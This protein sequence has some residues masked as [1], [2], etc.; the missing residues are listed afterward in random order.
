[1]VERD[2]AVPG[3]E[4][5]PEERHRTQSVDDAVAMALAREDPYAVIDILADADRFIEI[6]GRLAEE[7]RSA[8]ARGDR[9]WP[10]ELYVALSGLSDID[11]TAR[12]SSDDFAARMVLRMDEHN[13]WG[14]KAAITRAGGSAEADDSLE[15][16]S[17]MLRRI[18]PPNAI[19]AVA[20]TERLARAVTAILAADDRRDAGIGLLLDEADKGLPAGPRAST[21]LRCVALASLRWTPATPVEPAILDR[22]GHGLQAGGWLDA[23]G[24]PIVARAAAR[25]LAP[26]LPQK[27]SAALIA[28]LS[29]HARVAGRPREAAELLRIG[30]VTPAEP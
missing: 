24:G 21:S 1:M 22:L 26:R 3:G 11:D 7:A 17:A 13:A 29:E 30:G 5:A 4:V 23:P 2:H 6:P 14:L 10:A 12:W 9:T 27:E 15:L 28:R 18:A 16:V 8:E 25:W 19:G 20:A